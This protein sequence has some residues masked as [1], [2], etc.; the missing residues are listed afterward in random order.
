MTTLINNQTH[1][2]V[3]VIAVPA[4]KKFATIA[5]MQDG[6]E[7]T[8][9]AKGMYKAVAN[10]FFEHVNRNADIGTLG[11]FVTFNNKV[12]TSNAWLQGR[13]CYVKSFNV[14]LAA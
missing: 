6:T 12:V 4:G 10:F 7:I 11:E 1:L 8:L 2:I 5:I 14:E 9:K 13:N 3:K